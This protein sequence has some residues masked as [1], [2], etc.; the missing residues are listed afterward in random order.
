MYLL[1]R[2]A[3]TLYDFRGDDPRKCKDELL[4]TLNREY[5]A[6]DIVQ[7][8]FFRGDLVRFQTGG[9]Y[10]R[11]LTFA[12]AIKSRSP[13]LQT[14]NPLQRD[15]VAHRSCAQCFFPIT[16]MLVSLHHPNARPSTSA[17]GK[18]APF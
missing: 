13:A 6:G 12:Q 18:R 8:Q 9:Q 5:A 16:A 17:P 11:R 3:F 1:Y 7:I 10:C 4:S 2:A 14:S 15:S